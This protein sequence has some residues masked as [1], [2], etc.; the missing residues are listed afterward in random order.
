ME[1]VRIDNIDWKKIYIN[2]LAAD[3]NLQLGNWLPCKPVKTYKL[4]N[5]KL[6]ELQI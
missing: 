2:E 3:K 4:R 6:K 1:E 5:G